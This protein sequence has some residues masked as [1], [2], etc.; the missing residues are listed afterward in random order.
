MIENI[1]CDG[2]CCLSNPSTIGGTWAWVT[3]DDLDRKVRSASGVLTPED[4]G[5]SK[6]TNNFME[7]FAA[8]RAL[9]SVSKKWQGWLVTDSRVTMSRLENGIKASAN[10]PEWIVGRVLQLKK[11][12]KWK[13]SIVR[14]HPSKRELENGWS[15]G[16]P[17][18]K[19]NRL[20]D[21]LCREAGNR[22]LER[23]EM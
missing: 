12:R 13:V 10:L 2:G 22:F 19:W 20:A 17:V 21:K 6:I 23:R 3:V 8:I 11:D 4:A 5:V 9:E 1:Y 14:G 18:S 16:L 7:L 15:K